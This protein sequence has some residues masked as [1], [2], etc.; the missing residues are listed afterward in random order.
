M[1]KLEEKTSNELLKLFAAIGP[2][3]IEPQPVSKITPEELK[4]V[5]TDELDRNDGLEDWF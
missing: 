5:V 2:E 3:R 4:A 1:K